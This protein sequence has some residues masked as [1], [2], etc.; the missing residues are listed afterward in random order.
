MTCWNVTID[1]ARGSASAGPSLA[2]S[3]NFTGYRRGSCCSSARGALTFCWGRT[4]PAVDQLVVG[5]DPRARRLLVHDDGEFHLFA[6]DLL[7]LQEQW[8]VVG[9][10]HA[11]VD[12]VGERCVGF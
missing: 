8:L 4:R 3:P 11:D 2:R 10:Q 1:W 7:L 5:V 6:V 9:V 12:P